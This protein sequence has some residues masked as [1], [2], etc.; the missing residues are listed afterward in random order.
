MNRS[1]HTRSRPWIIC[2]GIPLESAKKPK[3][4]APGPLAVSEGKLKA[5]DVSLAA[6][7]LGKVEIAGD[8]VLLGQPLTFTKA[9][10]DQFDF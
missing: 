8:N 6:G 2:S 7:R 3:C 1:V 9:N 10:I 5:G 4:Q